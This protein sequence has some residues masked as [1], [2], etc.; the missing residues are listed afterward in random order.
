MVAEKSIIISS[1]NKYILHY[2]NIN[3]IALE[4]FL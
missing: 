1:H 3:N 2:S 4:K